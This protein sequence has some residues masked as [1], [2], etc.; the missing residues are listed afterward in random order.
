MRL[1]LSQVTISSPRRTWDIACGLSAMKQAVQD[2]FR[3]SATAMP[4]RMRALIRL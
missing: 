3:A 1:Q 4:L 2:P